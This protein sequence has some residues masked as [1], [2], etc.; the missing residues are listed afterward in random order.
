MNMSVVTI[1]ICVVT[2]QAAVQECQSHGH[3]FITT[4]FWTCIYHNCCIQIKPHVHAGDK[5]IELLLC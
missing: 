5:F 2:A 1:Y 3:V 4:D